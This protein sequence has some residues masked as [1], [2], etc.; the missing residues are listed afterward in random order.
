[1]VAHTRERSTLGK[2]PLAVPLGRKDPLN[3]ELA[4]EFG[5]RGSAWTTERELLL[6]VRHELSHVSCDGDEDQDWRYLSDLALLAAD[7]EAVQSDA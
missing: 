1:M 4:A 7:I 2:I 6:C 3:A 5:P